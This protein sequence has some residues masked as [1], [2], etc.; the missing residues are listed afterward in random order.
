MHVFSAAFLEWFEDALLQVLPGTGGVVTSVFTRTGNVIAQTGDYTYSQIS[1]APTLLSQFTNDPGYITSVPAQSFASLTGKPITIAGY[2]ITDAYTKT[3]S[4]ANYPLIGGGYIN[5]SWITSLPY[6]KIT[7][8]PTLVSVF[9]NDAGYLTSTPAQSFSSL[10]GKPTTLSGYGITDAVPSSRT[11]TIN[12]TTQDLSADRTFVIATASGTVTSIGLSTDATWMIVGSSPVT[13][14]GTITL[15][16]ATGLT[17]NQVLATP[18]GGTGTVGLR[19]LVLADIPSLAYVT[20]VA[21]TVPS[22]LSVSGSPI[23]TSGTLAI[24]LAN[25]VQNTV[26]AGSNAGGSVAPTFRAL[27]GADLPIVTATTTGA[28]STGSDT[29]AGNKTFNGNISGAN[30]SSATNIALPIQI[31][32]TISTAGV[33]GVNFLCTTP[34]SNLT[35]FT[36]TS[37]QTNAVYVEAKFNQAS[38]SSSNTSLCINTIQTAVGS[39][40]Q[41]LADFQVG[42][43]SRV[44]VGAAGGL[45]LAAGVVASGSLSSSNGLVLS[46]TSAK[47][48]RKIGSPGTDQSVTLVAGASTVSNSRVTANTVFSYIITTEGGTPGNYLLITPNA[49][50]GFAVASK[51]GGVASILDTSTYTITLDYE[52]LP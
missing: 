18:N 37:G 19:S 47:F 9:T 34:G 27:V 51:S 52:K 10:T 38:G 29:I 28:L 44:S 42:G 45:I 17:P 33:N 15:N 31:L 1:G 7:G 40:T 39:G 13:T 11:L 2:G 32:R 12:G 8:T 20:S 30:F 46:A 14:S 22:I 23:T 16:K 21:A 24:S 6:T 26:F 5:P 4:D 48:Y 50:V 25:Q 36:S 3:Q 49:G 41:L 43:V 35:I